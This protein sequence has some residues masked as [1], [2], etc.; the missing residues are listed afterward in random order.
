MGIPFY[1]AH[2]TVWVV[3]QNSLLAIRLSV[4]SSAH[5]IDD[6]L[7]DNPVTNAGHDCTM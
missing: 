4:P 6:I 7:V 3:S 2:A 5:K 1:I